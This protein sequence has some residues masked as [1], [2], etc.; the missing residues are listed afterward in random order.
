MFPPKHWISSPLVVNTEY[1][2]PRGL[3]EEIPERRKSLGRVIDKAAVWDS[4]LE[5][6]G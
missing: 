3:V 2:G 5:Y 4:E 1:S 6:L